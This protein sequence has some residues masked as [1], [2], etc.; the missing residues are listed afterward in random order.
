LIAFPRVVS[1]ELGGQHVVEYQITG[2][3]VSTLD[4]RQTNER[5][6][7]GSVPELTVA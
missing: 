6:G 3:E 2:D 5:F 1:P 4:D 7:G